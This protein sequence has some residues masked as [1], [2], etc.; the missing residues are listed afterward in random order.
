MAKKK[1]HSPSEIAAKLREADN[2]VS[3]GRSQSEIAKI[4]GISVM[5]FHRWRNARTAQPQPK[6][7]NGSVLNEIS[8]VVSTPERGGQIAD[9]RLENAR[10]RRLVMDLLLEKMKLEDDQQGRRG[11]ASAQRLASA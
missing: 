4:L 1:R 9:L 5:T 2:L 8:S 11:G 7:A 10:L 6:S 3:E